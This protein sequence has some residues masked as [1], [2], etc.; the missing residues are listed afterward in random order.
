MFNATSVY[1]AALLILQWLCLSHD[2]FLSM[3]GW[4]LDSKSFVLSTFIPCFLVILKKYNILIIL[5]AL[6]ISH[7]QKHSLHPFLQLIFIPL[8]FVG[9]F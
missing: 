1:A 7:P 6:E 5:T 8:F 4:L 3:A 9:E 2:Y